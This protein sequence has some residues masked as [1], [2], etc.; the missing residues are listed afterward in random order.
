[1]GI[2]QERRRIE[3]GA[4]GSQGLQSQ[5]ARLVS[6]TVMG[7]G[8]KM[9]AQKERWLACGQ[10]SPSS[11]LEFLNEEMICLQ[12]LVGSAPFRSSPLAH[13]KDRM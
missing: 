7:N 11:G 10:T 8:P 3:G 2:S 6:N 4:K 13:T 5:A 12:L 9:A 1:M